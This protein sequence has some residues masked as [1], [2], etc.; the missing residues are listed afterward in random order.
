MRRMLFLT[1]GALSA[2]L[3]GCG[4]GGGA[5]TPAPAQRPPAPVTTTNGSP[6]TTV[7]LTNAPTTVALPA[8]AGVSGAIVLPPVKASSGATLR[9]TTATQ[10]PAGAP[11]LQS[12]RRTQSGALSVLFFITFQ[13]SE[14]ITFPTL[15]AI[16]IDL[17]SSTSTAGQFFYAFSDPN[18]TD[19]ALKFRTEGPARVDA[20]TLGF[21]ASSTPLTIPAEQEVVF[22]F[23]GVSQFAR[24]PGV[25]YANYTGDKRPALD[26][27]QATGEF[28]ASL[29]RFYLTAKMADAVVSG[30]DNFYVWGVD[31]GGATLAP[32]PG[33]P[34][35]IFNSVVVVHVFPNGTF[36]GVVNLIPGPS[37]PLPS[38]NVFVGDAKVSVTVPAALLPSTGISPQAYLWNLWPRA[39]VGG[40]PSQIASFAPENEMA[41][42]LPGQ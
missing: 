18:A 16:T 14:T 23:Y 17:P 41:P 7:H 26:V 3:A 33:E 1:V 2:S 36:T 40:P 13:S 31:R 42:M 20:T 34:R 9:I 19:V 12:I 28:S 8:T 5:M 35:V 21:R 32:F 27:G 15:P 4:G 10:P 6:S 25:F 24:A 29:Q 30:N 39:A 37:T 22:A 38:G 11:Q